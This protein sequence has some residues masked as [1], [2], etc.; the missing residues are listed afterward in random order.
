VYFQCWYYNASYIK[1]ILRSDFNVLSQEALCVCVPPS[2]MQNFPVKYPRI[3]RF[4][5][6][7]E[8]V[9]KTMWP[10]KNMG[11]YYILTLQSREGNST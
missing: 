11:D 5:L 6:R 1:K 3:Y 7:S 8:S 10:W 4:L 9:L 2:Y